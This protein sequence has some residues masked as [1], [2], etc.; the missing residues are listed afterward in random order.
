MLLC[1]TLISVMFLTGCTSCASCNGF[2]LMG[3]NCAGFG[4]GDPQD[5]TV[6]EPGD[7]TVGEPN[8][9]TPEAPDEPDEP[10]ITGEINFKTLTVNGTAVSGVVYNAIDEYSF[11]NE[12]VVSGQ[13]TYTVSLDKQGEHTFETNKVALAEGDNIF[14]V[15]QTVGEKTT[16]YTVTIRRRPMYTVSFNTNSDETTV[17]SQTVEEGNCATAPTNPT[18][19]GYTFKSW[20]Y[21][22]SKPITADTTVE[23]QWSNN[24]Y[25]VAFNAAG[26]DNVASMSVVFDQSYTLPEPTK[27]GYTFLGWYYGTQ[28]VADGDEWSI[29]KSITLD[30][31]WLAN[32]NTSYRV[33]HYIELLDGTYE[34]KDTDNYTGTS[35]T[36]A[37]PGVKTYTGFTSPL[38]QT[39]IIKPDGSQVVEYYYTRNSYTISFITNGGIAV[40]TQTLKYGEE[41][42]STVRDGFTFGGWFCDAGM[43][44]ETS[45]APA[46]NTTLYAYWTEE[47]KASD[48]NYSVVGDTVN[49][50]KYQA[51]DATVR[52]PEY[53]EGKKVTSIGNEAFWYRTNL[54]NVTIPDSVTS[55]GADAFKGCT[56]LTNVTIGNGMTSIGE[57]MFYRCTSLVSVKIGNSVTSIGDNA[58]YRCTSLASIEI[59]DSVISIGA[60]AFEN[61]TSLTSVKIGSGVKSIGD[62]A[63]A[64]CSSLTAV[65]IPNSVETVGG[66]VFRDCS[67]LMSVTVGNGVTSIGDGAFYR[68]TALESITVDEDNASYMSIDGNLYSKDGTVLIQYAIAKTNTSFIIPNSVTSIGDGAFRNCTNLTSVTIHVGVNSIGAY[69]FEYCTSLTKVTFKN[70]AG[71][72]YAASPTATSGTAISSAFLSVQNKAAEYLNSN[73]YNYYWKRG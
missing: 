70:T 41:L 32:V 33:E 19:T 53:I 59:P 11:E 22:F 16:T 46:S 8:D 52:I 61:C 42:P 71:W 37:N 21:D 9:T 49:V 18:K 36:L 63:F 30:A 12:I 35:D 67:K 24:S 29:D 50:N 69:A 60:S 62:N 26:G 2:S 58:F 45:T 13:A 73:Y 56:S 38:K 40:A 5:T 43:L 20:S 65:A 14:Y 1:A 3:F 31:K 10:V 4:Q 68:C 55:L 51:N 48:F 39:V 47:N 28:R 7:T 27:V 6:E 23:A 44:T 64:Y 72:W 57:N 54:M 34:L 66:N 15:I 17:D 25:T